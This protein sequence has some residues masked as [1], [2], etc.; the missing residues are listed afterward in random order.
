MIKFYIIF[1]IVE[2]RN[3]YFS[4]SLIRLKFGLNIIKSS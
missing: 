4:K 2:D 3:T 1:A